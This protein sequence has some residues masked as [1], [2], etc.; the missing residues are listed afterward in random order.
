MLLRTCLCAFSFWTVQHN[1]SKLV[2]FTLFT[3][4]VQTNTSFGNLSSFVTINAVASSVRWVSYFLFLCICLSI[5]VSVSKET[6]AISSRGPIMSA[7][8]MTTVIMLSS[9]SFLPISTYSS[10]KAKTIKLDKDGKKLFETKISA[11]FNCDRTQ[12]F[13]IHH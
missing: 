5:F 9:S 11:R 13:N 10:T 8:L 12:T 4:T 1:Q 7:I 2:S 6:N 3:A